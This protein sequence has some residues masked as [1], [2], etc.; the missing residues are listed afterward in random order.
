[1]FPVKSSGVWLPITCTV[2]HTFPLKPVAHRHDIVY[3]G[4]RAGVGGGECYF[5]VWFDLLR[6]HHTCL[7]LQ[8]GVA[9]EYPQE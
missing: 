8:H 5:A 4:E 3:L 9:F 6:S 2:S 1:M 7:G